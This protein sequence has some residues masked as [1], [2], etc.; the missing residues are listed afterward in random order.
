VYTRNLLT[1]FELDIPLFA[2]RRL[3]VLVSVE[4]RGVNEISWL[5]GAPNGRH[6]FRKCSDKKKHYKSRVYKQCSGGACFL[7]DGS[8]GNAV[9]AEASGAD[10]ERS[11][12]SLSPLPFSTVK[13]K[14]T[15]F[16]MSSG[17]NKQG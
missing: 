6:V 12:L 1:N 5:T 7:D 9:N 13:T 4:R 10:R 11:R 15:I 17:R 16:V 8:Q 3:Q 2:R 14:N